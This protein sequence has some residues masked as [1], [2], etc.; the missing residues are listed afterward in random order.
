MAIKEFLAYEADTSIAF[1]KKAP[2]MP[3]LDKVL[4]LFRSWHGSFWV[5]SIILDFGLPVGPFSDALTR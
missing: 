2:E 3:R 1:V 5:C 4:V